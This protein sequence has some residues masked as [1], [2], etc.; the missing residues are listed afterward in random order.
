MQASNPGI[1]SD[2][3]TFLNDLMA[4]DGDIDAMPEGAHVNAIRDGFVHLRAPDD[5]SDTFKLP[6]DE[7]RNPPSLSYMI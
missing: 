3:R 1:K 7:A 4:A 6:G 5:P 2:E